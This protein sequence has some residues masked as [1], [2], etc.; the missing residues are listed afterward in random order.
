MS[1]FVNSEAVFS[2]IGDYPV[3]DQFDVGYSLLQSGSTH[4]AYITGSLLRYSTT[5]SGKKVLHQGERGRAF[6]KLG[7]KQ[8]TLPLSKIAPA[9]GVVTSSYE[10]QPWRERAG[11][12]KTIKLFSNDERFFDSLVP[13]ISEYIKQIN[14]YVF[15]TPVGGLGI[16]VIPDGA[17]FLFGNPGSPSSGPPVEGV[18]VGFNNYFPFEPAFSSISRVKQL[19]SFVATHASDFTKLAKPKVVNR[20]SII[21]EYNS[22]NSQFIWVGGIDDVTNPTNIGSKISKVDSSKLFFGFGDRCTT[23]VDVAGRLTGS[24]GL[25]EARTGAIDVGADPLFLVSPIIRGWKYGLASGL[26]HYTSCTFRRDRYGQFRDMLEQREIIASM[27]DEQNNSVWNKI[28]EDEPPAT[29]YVKEDNSK[30]LTNLFKNKSVQSPNT[31]ILDPP[32]KVNFVTAVVV[33][34]D[35][36]EGSKIIYNNETPSETWSSNLSAYATSS[37]PY[38]DGVSRNRPV[39]T[40][41]PDNIILSPIFSEATTRFTI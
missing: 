39:E 17:F 38:F 32:V 29:P 3:V 18:A 27:S 12:I 36:D 15:Y 35:N 11:T 34:I 25:P 26:P 41:P 24:L 10:F 30:S 6:S 16:S 14:G 21:Y 23:Q 7:V 4:D 2:V 13:N 22:E 19:D 37:L 28:V 33:K 9:P 20:I 8:S 1:H 40:T 31:F 5:L